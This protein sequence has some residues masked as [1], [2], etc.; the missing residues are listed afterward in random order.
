MRRMIAL[1]G[2]LILAVAIAPSATA[3]AGGRH[4][5]RR[6]IIFVHGFSGSGLQ[7]QTQA[8]RLASNGYPAESIETHDYDS[9]F[10]TENPE[11]VLTRLDQRIARLLARTGADR[12]DLLGH[13]LGTAMSQSY[14]ASPD[15]AARVAHYVNLDGRTAAAPPGGVPTLAVWGEGDP[16]R[17]IVG[18]TNVYFA[19][20]SHTQVVTS[21]ETFAEIYAFFTGRAPRTTRI[22]PEPF[23]VQ[24]SGRAV[25]FPTNVGVTGARLEIYELTSITGQRRRATPDATFE[26]AGDGSWG[27]FRGRGFA[28]YE[29]AIVRD[30]A[31]T[32]H[33]YFQPFLRT[34][35]LVMLLTS[36]PG[37]GL[38]AL[39]EVSDEHTNFVIS[40]NK[41]WWGDQGDA[42]DELWINGRNVLNA[43]NSPRAKRVIGIF[44]YDRNVDQVTDLAAPIPVFFSQPF[45]TGMDV[46]IPAAPRNL[47]LAV[48]VARSRG[49]GFD[50]LIV[51]NWPSTDHRISLQFADAGGGGS[52]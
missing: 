24:L 49:G 36:L 11:Q 22:V 47:G 48:V 52:T 6:P 15:R 18:A 4:P 20:Q 31:P 38:S 10:A 41:E 35:R 28:R 17:A 45:I 25:L 51:P 37:T 16:A 21:K 9:T 3:D 12:V 1:V 7:F 50:A 43:A 26:L 29:F 19:D 2:A 39:T 27:P 40:R 34:D 14:L 23:G 42:G 44:L 30:G 32:H 5:E 13:S 8:K 33:L 46:F